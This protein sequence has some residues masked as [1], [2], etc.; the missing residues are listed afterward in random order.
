MQIIPCKLS[1]AN[2]PH[3]HFLVQIILCIVYINLFTSLDSFNLITSTKSIKLNIEVYEFSFTNIPRVILYF[4]MFWKSTRYRS[5]INSRF[6][7]VVVSVLFQYR[8]PIQQSGERANSSQQWTSG[9]QGMHFN[10]S[11]VSERVN[12]SQQWTSGLQLRNR[13]LQCALLFIYFWNEKVIIFRT[14]INNPLLKIG[15]EK[16][17]WCPRFARK[18]HIFYNYICINTFK[19]TLSYNNITIDSLKLPFLM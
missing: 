10:R 6:L 18:A 5:L 8:I 7:V 13:K 1:H 16:D 19:I 3:A 9:L 11:W 17:P 2:Y 15:A 12:S 4:E 14:G